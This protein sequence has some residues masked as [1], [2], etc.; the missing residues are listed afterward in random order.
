MSYPKKNRIMNELTDLLGQHS[1]GPHLNLDEV[2]EV[3]VDHEDS[4]ISFIYQGQWVV[5]DV[6][7]WPI[8]AG[9]E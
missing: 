1:R 7:V 6:K 2:G 9:D 8:P 5:L 4:S 3:E